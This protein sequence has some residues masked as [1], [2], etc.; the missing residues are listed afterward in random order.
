MKANGATEFNLNIEPPVCFEALLRQHF[1]QVTHSSK[2]AF[3]ASLHWPY[4][5]RNPPQV[6]TYRN[7][8]TSWP[9]PGGSVSGS[10]GGAWSHCHQGTISNFLMCL[11]RSDAA[12]VY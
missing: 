7:A 10:A 5:H 11:D 8:E 6:V 3:Y 9:Y 2:N 1:S 4:P 12:V